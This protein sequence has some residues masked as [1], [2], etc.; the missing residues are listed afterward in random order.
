MTAGWTTEGTGALVSVLGQA[1]VESELDGVARNNTVFKKIAKEIAELGFERTW[2][3]CQTK[4]KNLT[5]KFR[6]V[7]TSVYFL[8]YYLYYHYAAF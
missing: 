3:Q 2:Q 5:Q 1:N 6:N 4:V 7:N 8:D